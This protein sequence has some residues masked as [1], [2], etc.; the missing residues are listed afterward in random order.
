MIHSEN[1]L[2]KVDEKCINYFSLKG[3]TLI[4]K[5]CSVYDG[6][7]CSVI[8]EYRNEFIKY[9][10][11]MMGYDCPEMKPLL[12]N[13]NRLIEISLAKAAK[14]RFIELVDKS[15]SGLVRMECFEF[16]K[17]GRLLADIYN[18]VDIE[19]VNSIMIREGH[20]RPYMGKHK[21]SW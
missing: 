7:T 3:N 21:D 18:N 6:D 2:L 9:K 19:S 4:A 20:G 17:Y 16:D 1:E 13:P 14:S 8:F 10:C 12:S 11:R 15:P 5:I